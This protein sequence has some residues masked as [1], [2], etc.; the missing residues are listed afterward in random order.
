MKNPQAPTGGFF[1]TNKCYSKIQDKDNSFNSS[2]HKFKPFASEI[3]WEHTPLETHIE[4]VKKHLFYLRNTTIPQVSY[5]YNFHRKKGDFSQSK[6]DILRERCENIEMINNDTLQLI[7]RFEQYLPELIKFENADSQARETW[8][9]LPLKYSLV[10]EYDLT[11]PDAT[12]KIS[13]I[14]YR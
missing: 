8:G 6:M 5:Y 1:K 10:F 3:H 2:R 14:L 4:V 9:K 11:H 13:A 12:K 7:A